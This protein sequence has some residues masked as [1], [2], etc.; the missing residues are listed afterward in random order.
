MEAVQIRFDEKRI[1]YEQ[2]LDIFWRHMDP[3]DPGGQFV[4]RGAQYRSAIFYH[5]EHQKEAALRSKQALD[6]SGKFQGPIVTEVIPF[7]RFY[8]AEA[9]HKAY[10]KKNPLRYQ[11]YR[12]HS[13]RDRF[14]RKIW[15]EQMPGSPQSFS[16]PADDLLKQRL[17]TLQYQVTQ[18]EATEPPFDNAYWDHKEE[19]IYVDVVSG[20]PLFSSTHKFDSG[21]GWPSF[22]R[23]LVPENIVERSDKR[24]FMVR[25]EVRSRNAE[26]HLG[27]LFDDGPQP[28]GLRYC[29]NSAAL[30]FIPKE[31]L[32]E[33]GHG[34]FLSLFT[35]NQP[36]T[37]TDD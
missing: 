32:D 37:G 11:L 29:I 3:T 20:E 14:L 18:E 26:S 12:K 34:R 36:V 13:G 7:K 28:T 25:T 4:D 21:T 35:A 23:A 1:S 15:S 6:N 31:H 33:K 8:P 19:G 9:Y 24:L 2:L 17:S 30:S 16:K 10:H 27:H 22:Y 5:D